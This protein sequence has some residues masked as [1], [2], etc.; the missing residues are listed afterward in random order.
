[1]NLAPCTFTCFTFLDRSRL[2]IGT[3][4][5]V[6]LA[7]VEARC[8][9]GRTVLTDLVYL[10]DTLHPQWKAFQQKVAR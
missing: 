6:T 2:L 3:N 7:T 9:H 1:M 10:A 4:Q 8:A 5:D